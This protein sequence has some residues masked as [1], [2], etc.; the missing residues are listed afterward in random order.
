MEFGLLGDL[1]VT[2]DGREVAVRGAKQRALLAALLVRR[3]DVVPADVLADDVWGDAPPANPAN[4][5]QAQVSQLRKLLPKPVLVT[6]GA[7]YLLDVTAAHLDSGR[8]EEAVATARAELDAGAPAAA[9]SRLRD[10][11]GLWRGPALA[12]FAYAEFARA[13]AARLEELRLA[14]LETRLDADLKCGRHGE[15]V[16]ELEGLCD[17]HPLRE[18]LW[19]LRMLALYRCGRQADALRAYADAR[20]RL[21]EELGI[22]PGPELR[23][24]EGMILQQDPA[25]DPNGGTT[26]RSAAAAATA[27]TV[28]TAAATG[29]AEG[30]RSGR[31]NLRARL[32][33]FVGRAGEV[34]RLHGLLAEHRLV[35]I[36]GPGGAGKTRLA[37]E[38]ADALADSYADGAWL[39]ELA[40]VVDADETA[41]AIAA[42]LG[43][44][45]AAT[46]R[47]GS[48]SG[49]ISDSISRHLAGR[50]LLVVVD[51]CEHVIDVAAALVDE[52]LGRVPALRVLAT[53]R[54]ALGVSGEVLLPLA[55]LATEA[56]VELFADRAQA[57]EPSFTLDV[58][59]AATVTEI[60]ER[61]DG[62]PLAIELA[63]ARLR[64]LPLEQ[65]AARLDDR[66]RLL[67]GG[68]RTALPRQ[69]TLRAVVD[70]SHDLLFDDERRLFAR[71]SVFPGGCT[72]AAAEE[73]CADARLP[74]DDVVDLL[75]RLVDKSL[76]VADRDAGGVRYRQLQTLWQYAR[77]RLAESGEA[78]GARDAH[79]AW[80]RSLAAGAEQG[81]RGAT[82]PTWRDR[83]G[84]ELDNLRAA[85]DWAI[86]RR[87]APSAIAI[88]VGIA[89]FWFLRAEWQ[90]AVRWLGDALAVAEAEP[91]AAAATE[92]ARAQAWHAYFAAMVG[93]PAEPIDRFAALESVLRDAGDP[94]QLGEVQLLHASALNRALRNEDSLQV[95]ARAR[96]ALTAADETWG[97]GICDLLAATAYARLGRLDD[98]DAHAAASVAQLESVGERLVIAEPMGLRASILDARGD[99]AG[100]LVAYEELTERCRAVDAPGYL[101]FWLA[102]QAAAHARRGDDAAAV[103]A[104]A[105]AREL[106]GTPGTIA[107]ADLGLARALA[108]QADTAVAQAH[109]DHAAATY[110]QLARADGTDAVRLASALTALDRGDVVEARHLAASVG[111][112]DPVVAD[113]ARATAALAGGDTAAAARALD[114]CADAAARALPGSLA[115]LLSP[116][117]R[118]LGARLAR[119]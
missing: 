62:L 106:R 83:L 48:T 72:L 74:A 44:G 50:A 57:V 70:W 43:V 69:Q 16:G 99:H 115:G 1:T 66:F 90:T 82:A 30:T 78:D 64:S 13:E 40:P 58:T 36:V 5:L 49:S 45:D 114:A 17:A 52:L 79:V 97:L 71:L 14:A 51:N 85:L 46:L 20:T 12:E 8:V 56:A 104:F 77:E 116:D 33:H 105:E 41:A 2:H 22:E 98:A 27:A 118:H 110:S 108:R 28:A 81:L 107:F 80:Y 119:S 55:P 88:A 35:T 94:Q 11:L 109:L 59:T 39:V 67:T 117:H 68:A 61:L 10:A 96:E 84:H 87:D 18:H 47:D 26:P 24:L 31:G 9:A 92:V 6:R 29:T 101:A 19:A 95:L 73:V 32:T 4:A 112:A 3:G 23:R 53:S 76:V 21:V 91:A 86:E 89:W 93:D 54:E 15:V 42:A 60:C 25:L 38:V 102:M 113:L 111:D 63:A 7:G 103:R 100:A 75:A 34:E 65:V 37:V